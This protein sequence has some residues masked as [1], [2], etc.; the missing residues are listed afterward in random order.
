MDVIHF[1]CVSTG[2]STVQLHDNLG[3]RRACACSELVS[4][5][6]MAIGFEEYTNEEQRLFFLFVARDSVQKIHIRKCFLCK[7]GSVCWLKRFTAGQRNVAKL[8]LMTKRL[9]RR[10]WSAWG[11]INYAAGFDALVKRLEKCIDVGGR[12]VDKY[13]SLFPQI[14]ISY[15]LRF[16]S[17]SD[18]FTDSPLYIRREV[19]HCGTHI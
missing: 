19:R 13:M 11:S 4:V 18:L 10:C 9:K 15:I 2:S 1:L 17:I 16:L 3:I 8:S 5:V 14:P 6:K 12:N 7:V